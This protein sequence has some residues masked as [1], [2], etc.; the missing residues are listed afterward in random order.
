MMKKR[1]LAIMVSAFAVVLLAGVAVAQIADVL[2][3][4][5]DT[6]GEAPVL[7]AAETGETSSPSN[8][9]I[10]QPG[11]P[12]PERRDDPTSA[13]ATVQEPEDADRGDDDR[14]GEDV[15]DEATKDE[16]PAGDE[17][18]DEVPDTTP[19]EFVILSPND[20][21]HVDDEVIK[22]SGEVEAG[23]K[24]TFA[25]RYR[26][27]VTDDGR[28]WI[29]LTLK[30]GRNVLELVAT[31]AAGN[32]SAASVTVYFDTPSDHRFSAAQK[33][34]KVDGSPAANKYYG[35]GTPGAHLWIVSEKGGAE[36]KITVG[37]NG[38]WSAYI[39]F[40]K[41]PCNEWFTVVVEADRFR[42]SFEMKWVCPNATEIDFTANQQ[43]GSCDE[44]VPYDVFWGTEDA[45][46][47]VVVSS[48]YGSAWAK[49]TEHGDWELR[50]EFPD[51]PVGE[52]FEIVVESSD[53]GRAVFTFTRTG[54]GDGK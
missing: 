5:D 2:P 37:E 40:P 52:P 45:G 50:V 21:A 17:K 11:E 33:W 49:A 28:W 39:E 43:Y 26:A 13:E 4:G 35:T 54:T 19:P 32:S 48:K 12:A 16:E 1:G 44:P 47:K 24:V 18:D 41:A 42:K 30:P 8:D 3:G 25:G 29:A 23:A 7:S 38:E 53:G 34:D 10:D 46:A 6:G 31:D 20:G 51:A 15:E 9:G 27:D 14:K 22:V 36:Q